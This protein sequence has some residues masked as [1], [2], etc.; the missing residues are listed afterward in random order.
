MASSSSEDE[1]AVQED[2]WQH[3][4]AYL[5][6]VKM[7][8][9]NIAIQQLNYSADI[10]SI[11][12]HVIMCPTFDE[13]ISDSN[14]RKKKPKKSSIRQCC[15]GDGEARPTDGK[16]APTDQI[17]NS[18][19]KVK[20]LT[21]ALK[22]QNH[23]CTA[24]D[25]CRRSQNIR[26][27]MAEVLNKP[28]LI[29]STKVTL[30]GDQSE[31]FEDEIGQETEGDDYNAEEYD[32]ADIVSDGEHQTNSVRSSSVTGRSAQLEKFKQVL[33]I[34]ESDFHQIQNDHKK[35]EDVMHEERVKTVALCKNN[36]SRPPP[37][38]VVFEDRSSKTKIEKKLRPVLDEEA[39]VSSGS[40]FDN[41]SPTFDLKRARFEVRKF[42]ISGLQGSQKEAGMIDLLVKLGAKPPKK[43]YMNY[44]ELQQ[45]KKEEQ[46]QVAAK[47]KLV[48][49]DNSNECMDR[50]VGFKV[51]KSSNKKRNRRDHN[52]VGVVDGQVG[53]YHQGVQVI[54]KKHLEHLT[55]NKHKK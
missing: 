43:E 40:V 48:R 1:Q 46:E 32:D 41:S 38:V 2:L 42:G 20:E 12:W 3:L 18:V 24:T 52:D 36:R 13:Q 25:V 21:L 54:S 31:M 14:T 45:K 50:S 29:D 47:R 39:E 27:K 35:T 15:V 4:S 30:S 7:F 8:H 23:L 37:T 10:Y 44:K 9:V 28:R 22:R 11:N 53:S 26:N 17:L 49:F 34:T 5:G 33:G 51:I 19:S 55:K 16:R 6:N